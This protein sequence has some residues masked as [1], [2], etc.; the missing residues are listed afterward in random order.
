[1]VAG[2][3]FFATASDE[4]TLLD[5]LGEPNDVRLFPWA[6][7]ALDSPTFVS[8]D[9]RRG[10]AKLGVLNPALGAV[11]LIRP[12]HRG[13]DTN[14]KAGIFNRINW[15]RAQPGETHGIVDWNRTPGLFWER[16]ASSENVLTLSSL[17]SQAD[18]MAAISEDY[19]K[20]VNRSMSWIRRV[21]VK[22][23][24]WPSDGGGTSPFD[25]S[26]PIANTVWALPGAVA[27]FEAGGSGR[28]RL[29]A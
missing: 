16:G 19:R 4:E 14:I 20:W 28:I 25:V 1:M 9:Q 10:N 3:H 11:E 6:P 27:L 13:F 29:E 26:L 2:V 8:R 23:W 7:M 12:P 5:Y 15:S 24:D 18:S 17:G 22:A 21:G